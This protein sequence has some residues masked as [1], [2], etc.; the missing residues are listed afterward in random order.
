M[1][2]EFD[3]II[4]GASSYSGV[5]IIEELAKADKSKSIKWAIA[6]R[7]KTKLIDALKTASQNSGVDLQNIPLYL[8]DVKDEITLKEICAKTKLLINC[9]G[10]YIFYGEPVV[11][12]CVENGT[13]YLDICGETL[14]LEKTQL[15]YDKAATE[16]KMFIIGACG[17]D[18][19]PS[20]M[21]VTFAENNFDGQLDRMEG[22][23]EFTAKDW[24][25]S[26][27][28]NYAT[29][30][31][32]LISLTNYDKLKMVRNQLMPKR[33]PFNKSF[34][35]QDRPPLFK[36]EGLGNLGIGK[37]GGDSGE[38]ASKDGWCLPF[39][40]T[41]KSVVNR[42]QYYMYEKEGKRPLQ[43]RPYFK[44]ESLLYAILTILLGGIVYLMAKF[45]RTRKLMEMYPQIFTGGQVRVND[46][47]SRHDLS[48][49]RFRWIMIAK[50]YSYSKNPQLRDKDPMLQME[51]PPDA[52]I[53]V[54]ISGPDAYKT[55]AICATQV[56][57]TLHKERNKLPTAGGVLT[58]AI[59]F[60]KTDL[61]QNLKDHGI[62]FEVLSLES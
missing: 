3:I 59:A 4:F 47:P 57:L 42:S 18:C 50:G 43:F 19:V 61:I 8:G 25:A 53:K 28:L 58:T 13:D 55:T 23:C 15:K 37:S 35:M 9:V 2:R 14:V 60:H 46:S 6:G 33:L 51:H 34:P 17:F 40:G 30:L 29:F 1:T 5:F 48:K 54:C 56:A 22:Y 41:D 24:G 45:K 20:D 10:P 52:G 7:N 62:K 44:V 49:S 31:S 39:P 27:A 36:S 38:V 12:A 26:P 32:A 16:A 21:G 11:K